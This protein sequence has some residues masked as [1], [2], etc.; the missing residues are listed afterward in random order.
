[1]V[2]SVA[3]SDFI[4]YDHFKAAAIVMGGLIGA[5]IGYKYC[6]NLLFF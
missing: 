2:G 3:L 1:M 5:F 6:S 4:P